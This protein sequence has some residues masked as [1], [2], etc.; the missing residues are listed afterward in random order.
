MANGWGPGWP[1]CAYGDLK[2]A[3]LGSRGARVSLRTGVVP[4]AE[5]VA[6]LAQRT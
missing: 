4:L 3:V 1:S 5:A 2:V 6:T